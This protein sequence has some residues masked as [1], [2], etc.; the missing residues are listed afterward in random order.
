[1]KNR[2]FEVHRGWTDTAC[3]IADILIGLGELELASEYV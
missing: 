1:V 3:W 2:S